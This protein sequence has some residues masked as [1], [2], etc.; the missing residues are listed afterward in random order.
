MCDDGMGMGPYKIKCKMWREGDVAIFDFDGTD[1]QAQSSVNFYLNEDM[2][3]MFFGSFT[4][5][6]VDPH[7][8]FNDGFY[9]LVDVRIFRKARLLKP[10]FPAA[11]SGRTH[12]LGRIFDVLGALLGA[13]APEQMLNAAGFSDSPHL[14]YSGYDDHREG[15]ETMSGSNCSRSVSAVFPAGRLATVRMGTPCGPVLRTCRTSSSSRT[16]RCVSSGTKRYLIRVV[17]ACTVAATA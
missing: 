17:P 4:I 9:D 16:S 6:V 14:F 8:V 15:K 10:K 3:K 7:I 2:F 11:L 12:A 5:N 13:G 1:P